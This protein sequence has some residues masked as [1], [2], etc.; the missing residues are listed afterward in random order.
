M[1]MKIL[2]AIALSAST[3]YAVPVP[4]QNAEPKDVSAKAT[5][6]S[7]VEDDLAKDFPASGNQFC[8][9]MAATHAE[10]GWGLKRVRKALGIGIVNGNSPLGVDS[11]NSKEKFGDF[12]FRDFFNPANVDSAEVQRT[13][14][15][16]LQDSNRIPEGSIIII[17]DEQPSCPTNAHGT[18]MVKCGDGFFLPAQD[19]RVTAEQFSEDVKKNAKCF[20]SLMYAS[21]WGGPST[22][23]QPTQQTQPAVQ[24]GGSSS[25][26]N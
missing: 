19:K 8:D 18:I 11:V 1:K 15:S 20:T 4:P 9:R 17:T 21:K 6:A 23:D 12:G 5:D 7:D 22:A 10:P 24:T 13:R 3:S 26:T 16:Y 25:V 2:L 14:E